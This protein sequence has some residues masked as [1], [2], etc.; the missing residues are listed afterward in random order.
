MSFHYVRRVLGDHRANLVRRLAKAS[1]AGEG[2]P[3]KGLLER[4]AEELSTA[5]NALTAMESGGGPTEQPNAHR[6]GSPISRRELVQLECR[7]LDG[8][9][10]LRM[11]LGENDVL[12][13]FLREAVALLQGGAPGEQ[14]RTLIDRLERF[15]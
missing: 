1:T 11:L 10:Q 5:I 4:R 12:R 15:L 9:R 2:D 3:P 6:T 7:L 13:T 14:V 8:H